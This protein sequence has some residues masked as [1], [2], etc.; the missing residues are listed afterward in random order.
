MTTLYAKTILETLINRNGWRLIV[1]MLRPPVTFDF[2]QHWRD[3]YRWMLPL[4]VLVAAVGIILVVGLSR[5]GDQSAEEIESAAR[6]S[7]I[8]ASAE[9]I[10]DPAFAVVSP[11]EM[12][13]T[14]RVSTFDA[15]VGTRHA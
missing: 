15:P 13:K 2:G 3:W 5:Q 1:E 12:V 4:V 7:L 9:A 11:L 10:Y 8:A 14:S 6:L